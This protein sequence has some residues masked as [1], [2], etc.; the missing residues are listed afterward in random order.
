MKSVQ[1]PDPP[2][3]PTPDSTPPPALTRPP[4]RP[5]LQRPPPP[6]ATPAPAFDEQRKAGQVE[7]VTFLVSQGS[8]ATF[9]AR[10][11]LVELPLPND[12]VVRTTVLSGE[13]HLDGRPSVI[14]IDLHQLRSDQDK[15]DWYIRTRMFPQHPT[16]VFTVQ[17]M[18]P[19][20]EGFADGETVTAQVSGQ[21]NIR[22]SVVPLTFAIEARDDGDVI[23]ILA[24]T[25][26]VW[27]DLELAAPFAPTF[28]VR[29][30]DEVRVEILLAVRPVL[31]SAAKP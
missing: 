8:E 16:A 1:A 22:G 11:Q 3:P 27:S 12:A 28:V 18:G 23:F 24:R 10:E 30:Q 25:S 31:A 15:R 19:A 4:R 14:E 7:G 9:T 20:P 17:E 6:A 13:V 2:P 21:L 26:F 29:V 5:R